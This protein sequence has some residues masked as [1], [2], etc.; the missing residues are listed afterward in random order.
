[1]TLYISQGPWSERYFI[2]LVPN[3]H[4]CHTFPYLTLRMFVMA[5]IRIDLIEENIK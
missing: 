5:D 3:F 2:K 4:F 1:M